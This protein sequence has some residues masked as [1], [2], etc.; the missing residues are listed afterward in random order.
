[1][2]AKWPQIDSRIHQKIIKIIVNFLYWIW[3]PCLTHVGII[4]DP[5]DPW[6]LSSRID[7]VLFF[8]CLRC[9]KIQE[10]RIFTSKHMTPALSTRS[11]TGEIMGNQ[12]IL[13]DTTIFIVFIK[14]GTSKY[15]KNTTTESTEVFHYIE[16]HSEICHA[17]FLTNSNLDQISTT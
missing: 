4:L 12:E 2:H 16:S 14:I 15:V 10:I 5:P 6:L 9:R 7:E 11:Q 13:Q 1:M 17:S 8:T 3:L